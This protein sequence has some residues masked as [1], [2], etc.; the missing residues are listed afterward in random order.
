VP[1]SQIGATQ[2]AALT[3]SW[4]STFGT[5]PDD[6]TLGLVATATARPD[7]IPADARQAIINAYQ[8]NQGRMPSNSEI[9]L[10]Y[11]GTK[12]KRPGASQ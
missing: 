8:K 11:V 5:K 4:Q 1:V 7:Q 9:A 2:K 12:F 3:Q 6:D 10:Q